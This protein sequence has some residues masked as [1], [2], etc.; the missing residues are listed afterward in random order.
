L[1]RNWRPNWRGRNLLTFLQKNDWHLLHSAQQPGTTLSWFQPDC[2]EAARI[3]LDELEKPVTYHSRLRFPLSA[4]ECET[5]SYLPEQL[6]VKLDR[7]SMCCA[8]ECRTPFLDR[9][10]FAF[11]TSLPL[12]YHFTHGQGKA[13]LRRALPPWVPPQIRWRDKQGFTPPLAH[14]F[15]TSLRARMDDAIR[16]LSNGLGEMFVPAAVAEL[17]RQ[18]LAGADHSPLLFRWLVLS[19]VVST[20]N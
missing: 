8:L 6:L 2:R 5:S 20:H 18:H 3:G 11:A 7:A 1:L 16:K 12:E 14:W 9:Q 4:M 19:R 17:N 15:R 10:L 13:L